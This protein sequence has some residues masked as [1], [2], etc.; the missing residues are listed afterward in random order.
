M[1]QAWSEAKLALNQQWL[2][3]LQEMGLASGLVQSTAMS[4]HVDD[5]RLRV[6]SKFA[7]TTLQSYFRIWKRWHDFA[8]QLAVCPFQPDAAF[9]ADFLAEHAHGPLGVA[10][11]YHK[12]LTWMAR[13][14]QLTELFQALQQSVCKAYLH[15][16]VIREK[17]ESA[18]LPLSF[19]VFLEKM[20][21]SIGQPQLVTFCS[22]VHCFSWYGAACDGQMHCGWTHSPLQYN[23]MPCLLWRPTP[24]RPTGECR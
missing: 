1:Q 23:N 22:W 16:A 11:A 15:S 4:N 17:R 13:H 18:P 5:H 2:E 14:A 10:T 24:R 21:L 8:R 3:L 9:L 6:I 20:M 7:P 19:V 12:G